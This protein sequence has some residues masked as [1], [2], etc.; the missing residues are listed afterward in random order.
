M[1]REKWTGMGMSDVRLIRGTGGLGG[2]PLVYHMV[3]LL[4]FGSQQELERAL[5]AHGREI[6]ADIKNY[7][8]VNPTVQLN[9]EVA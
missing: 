5:Q 9:E 8:N 6:M 2:E 7:T 3:A 4:R 1:L